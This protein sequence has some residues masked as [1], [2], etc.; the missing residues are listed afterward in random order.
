MTHWRT[1]HTDEPHSTWRW[2]ALSLFV[3]LAVVVGARMLVPDRVCPAD[4][5]QW[6]QKGIN[7]GPMCL[8]TPHWWCSEDAYQTSC[9]H[10]RNRRRG[11]L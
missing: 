8:R 2:L 5:Y 4:F 6:V 10:D 1:P 9:L 3:C 11:E 7:L